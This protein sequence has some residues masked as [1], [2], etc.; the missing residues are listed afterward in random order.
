M[1]SEINKKTKEGWGGILRFFV[2]RAHGYIQPVVRRL[3]IEERGEN[4]F[5][6]FHTRTN[7]PKRGK[8]NVVVIEETN[9]WI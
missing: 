5:P 7:F 3:I 8:I 4:K 2:T 1:I 6:P 9:S